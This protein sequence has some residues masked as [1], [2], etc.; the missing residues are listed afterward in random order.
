MSVHIIL[1]DLQIEKADDTYMDEEL[2][3]DMNR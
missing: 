2:V 1:N 3:A